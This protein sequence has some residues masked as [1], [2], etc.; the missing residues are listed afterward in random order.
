[1]S[2][3]AR[4]DLRRKRLSSW[5][6]GVL[7]CASAAA[8]STDNV[9]GS[10]VQFRYINNELLTNYRLEEADLALRAME[11]GP[12]DDIESDFLRA[13][14]LWM[15]G[16]HDGANVGARDLA[17]SVV[18]RAPGFVNGQ[19][20]LG[21]LYI[22]EL[23]FA[24]ADKQL[25]IARKLA[26]EDPDT[27]YLAMIL[28]DIHGRTSEAAAL[29]E[30]IL[31]TPSTP[32]EMRTAV[33]RHRIAYADR[34]GDSTAVERDWQRLVDLRDGVLTVHEYDQLSRRRIF[35]QGRCDDA[36]DLLQPT[37]VDKKLRNALAINI[38]SARVCL[39]AGLAGTDPAA[40]DAV[41]R[42]A[43]AENPAAVAEVFDA[44]AGEA[45]LNRRVL[46]YL[47]GRQADRGSVVRG[48][49]VNALG[50]QVL[51]GDIG[52]LQTLLEMGLDP[53]APGAD[54]GVQPALSVVVASRDFLGPKAMEMARLLVA[55]GADP[56][57]PD[58][59]G[60]PANYALDLGVGTSEE[61][62]WATILVRGRPLQRGQ[63]PFNR[64]DP[65]FPRNC[66][67]LCMTIGKQRAGMISE[68]LQMP[69]T[70][71]NGI[72]GQYRPVNVAVHY[73]A[74]NPVIYRQIVEE[75]I[76]AGADP[77][78]RD[79]DGRNAMDL[80]DGLGDDAE[81]DLLPLLTRQPG[82]KD[83]P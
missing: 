40:A 58:L 66:D 81:A 70:R 30:R 55:H 47:T 48:S 32:V 77:T 3:F 12:H 22:D 35:M 71:I 73:Y 65:D 38:A 49:S 74:D 41:Y 15:A 14:L 10:S 24:G 60:R 76:A 7:L 75:L 50:R 80:L 42:Q 69:E 67:G 82:K 23:D 53:N 63:R 72:E 46:D 43:Q 1:M 52:N 4:V 44:F 36:M 68:F 21:F 13:R 28:A 26:P 45:V 61:Q 39:A 79:P 34:A 6:F 57:R 2:R 54:A 83:K 31:A 51:R 64:P 27:W 78:L 19:R 33:L 11:L 18:A 25:A 37:L 59:S 9:P 16:P 5:V 17:S 29:S 62:A 20:L 56:S 8:C